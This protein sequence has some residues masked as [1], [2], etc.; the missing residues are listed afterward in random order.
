MDTAEDPGEFN[1][2]P[3]PHT[4]VPCGRLQCRIVTHL[5]QLQEHVGF[6][7]SETSGFWC[8]RLN[9]HSSTGT[10]E[11]GHVKTDMSCVPGNICQDT[12]C[13]RH[14]AQL[15]YDCIP[16]KC[17]HRGSCDNNRNCHCHISWD[18]PWCTGRGTG[19]STG[20]GP[21]QEEGGQ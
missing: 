12:Y 3:C 5:P 7:P 6:H 2:E 4:D 10:T 14:V 9:S 16:E 20:S 15:N 1:T 19:G 17:S 13:S 18:P 8:L 21:L 11:I